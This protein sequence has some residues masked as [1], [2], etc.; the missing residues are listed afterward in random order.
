MVKLHLR[1]GVQVK[2]MHEDRVKS[3][4]L[5]SSQ[6]LTKAEIHCLSLS[7]KWQGTGV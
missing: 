2:K 1:I 5:A 4:L 6:A 7:G 3:H